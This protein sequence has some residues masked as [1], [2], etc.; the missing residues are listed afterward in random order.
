[1]AHLQEDRSPTR[2]ERL[3]R[4]TKQLIG[5]TLTALVI[6]GSVFALN[7]FLGHKF[8]VSWACFCTGIIGGFVSVQQ[9]I[10]KISEEELELL[11]GSWCQVLLIPVYGGIFA[12]VLYVAFLSRVVEGPLF[13]VFSIPAFSV[14]PL[15]DDLKN[16]F[17]ATYPSTGV[18]LAKLIFWCFIAGFSE[19]PRPADNQYC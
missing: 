16:M 1:M 7:L 10:K 19:A 8:M 6:L 11:S 2:C 4:V 9:R 3:H 12:L 5:M 14:P 15:A 18:D 13:P 17:F